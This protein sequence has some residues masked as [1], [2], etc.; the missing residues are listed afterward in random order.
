MFSQ[1]KA[2]YKG[3]ISTKKFFFFAAMLCG[4]FISA[5]YGVSRPTS[6]AFFITHFSAKLFP[7]AWLFSLLLNLG[8]ISFYNWVLPKIGA[9]RFFRAFVC[10]VMGISCISFWFI[11]DYPSI[12]FFHFIWKDIYILFMFKQLWS[13][14]HSTIPS[15]SAKSLYGIIFAAGG[16]GS[17][18]GS[19]FPGF[20]AIHTGSEKLLILTVPFYL[21]VF[22]AYRF[23]YRRSEVSQGKNL[24]SASS[25]G[26]S[27][28][29]KIVSS[30]YLFLLLFLVISM[31]TSVALIDFQFGSFLEG[32]IQDLDFR[33]QYYAR[34]VSVTNLVSTSF[35]VL[36]GIFLL[37]WIA[38][39]VG[40]CMIPLFL[41]CNIFMTFLF[42]SL[43]TV[44]YSYVSLKSVDYSF[45]GVLRELLY[46]PLPL[47]EKF[48]VKA[49]IDV[50]A[51]RS[52]KALAS[53]FLLFFP[54]F[55]SIKP[56]LFS[57]ILLG[58]VS[59]LWF[60]AA[61]QM[62][63]IPRNFLDQKILS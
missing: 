21:V 25:K 33:T 6:N 27:V 40:H 36:L 32:A 58:I 53:F 34:V 23:A 43:S 4:F 56:L 35:Q 49:F 42:P 31:Q 57:T 30:K 7:Y 41:G 59:L 15:S 60:Y 51:Y 63:K 62:G 20:L 24:F 54:S 48:R 46:A 26:F 37:S 14:I 19:L 13:M 45:F 44:S 8:I 9:Y 17:V 3:L 5:E 28:V 18:I 38:P 50:F 29:G 55:F 47:D 39:A 2:H 12:S 52:A 11:K 10:F 1:V 61:F 16:V 22:F